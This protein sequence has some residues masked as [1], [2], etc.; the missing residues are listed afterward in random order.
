VRDHRYHSLRIARVVRETADANSFV[1]EVPDELAATFAH[2]AGQFCTF[3]LDVDGEARYRCY[4]MSSAPALGEPLQVTVK[5]VRDGVVSNFMNDTLSPGT[6]IDVAPPGGQFC[7]TAE[8]GT[9]VAF[10]A[11]SGITP[12]IS[13]V[14]TAL[15]TTDRPVRMLYA[16]RDL[17]SVIFREALDALAAEHGDRFTLVHHLDAEA[18]FLTREEVGAL[19]DGAEAP[20]VFVCGPGPFMDL[21]EQALVDHGVATTH[22]HI[23]RFSSTDLPGPTGPLP[24]EAP[25]TVRVTIELDGRVDTADHQPG[26]TVLQTARQLG[27]TPPYSCEMG[28]CATCMAKVVE[29]AVM[30]HANTVLTDAEVA[31]GWVLTCQS[32]PTTPSVHVVYG[33]EEI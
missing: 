6:T 17:D 18:G 1:L 25:G 28:N 3:R 14:K 32:V 21:V 9:V 30:M 20:E 15:A 33:L 24:G 2:E 19:V 8:R 5:R 11:G 31:D 7:L 10:G 4:S 29:G 26:A 22:L 16:N 27:M 12:V 23:E 13:I